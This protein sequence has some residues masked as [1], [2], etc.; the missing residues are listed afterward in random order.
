MQLIYLDHN[1]TTPVAPAAQFAAMRFLENEFGNPSS[2]HAKGRVAKTTVD[3]AREALAELLGAAAAEIVFTGSATESNNMALLGAA[4]AAPAGRRHLVV[5]AIE[6]PA[7]MEPALA[8]QRQ[9]WQLSIAPVDRQGLLQVEALQSML[10]ADTAIVS[11]MH[12]NN[13]LGTLQPIEQI[14]PLVRAAGALLHVDAAQSIGKVPVNVNS[15]GVDLLTVA[16]HKMYAPK[17]IGALYVRRGTRLASLFY[18]AGQ[19]HGRRPGTENVPYIA[20]LGAAAQYVQGQMT[21][22]ASRVAELRNVLE[23]RLLTGIPGLIVNGDPLNRLPNTSHVSLPLG[24]VRALVSA[25]ADQVALSPGAACHSDGNDP[26]SGVMRAIGASAQQAKGALRLSL[27]YDTTVLQVE[28]AANL[29]CLAYK[30]LLE[31]P[32]GVATPTGHGERPL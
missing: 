15:L 13:E 14:A 16:G 11:V 21:K 7:V 4:R 12:A 5:S 3:E 27:G 31:L 23:Q 20:A 9:G 18:G 6:H 29:I 8:L 22:S 17:G 10:R 30:N 24:D 26:V 28:Q 25:L 2:T 19:E 32:P 1:A